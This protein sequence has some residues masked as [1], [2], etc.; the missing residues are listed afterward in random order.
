MIKR[1]G[2]EVKV[3]M[4]RK[5]IKLVDICEALKFDKKTVWATLYGHEN[6]R[7]VLAWLI[8]KGCPKK[9]LALPADMDSK[10]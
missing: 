6:N 3:W 2:I 1:N 5:N 4:V 9:H 7:K 8:D 10:A